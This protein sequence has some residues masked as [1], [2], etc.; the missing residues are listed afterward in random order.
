MARGD[1]AAAEPLD[2][3]M[4]ALA[5]PRRR[6]ILRLVAHDELAAGEIAAAFDVTRTAVSQHLTVLKTAGLLTERRDGTRRLYRARPEGL[7]EL[8][9]FLEE[10]WGSSLDAAR[11][12]VEQDRAAGGGVR[13]DRPPR[14]GAGPASREGSR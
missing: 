3:A 7:A 10:M 2:E 8:R 14:T 5:E 13:H 6:A 12:L 9:E 11:R 4:R 1:A